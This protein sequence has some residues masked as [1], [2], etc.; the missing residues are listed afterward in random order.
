M[1]RLLKLDSIKNKVSKRT[2]A[3]KQPSR[4]A[5]SDYFSINSSNRELSINTTASSYLEKSLDGPRVPDFR[6]FISDEENVELF[7]DF[8]K[9]QYCQENIEFYVACEKFKNLDANA[10]L[11]SFMANQIYS[12]YLSETAK[13]PVN[14]N[15]D[16]LERIRSK[17]DQPEPGMFDDAQQEI[18]E[19][20][21]TDCYPRFCKTWRVDR[22]TA[23][24]ICQADQSSRRDSL[25]RTCVRNIVR[26][27]KS[28]RRRTPPPPPLP[29]KPGKASKKPHVEVDYH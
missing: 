3:K 14:L 24:K 2:P 29:P 5:L 19:L 4:A 9:S 27:T 15:H 1:N 12:A 25:R 8:L 7:R 16:C 6:T 22:E 21:R 11:M 23:N 10:E 17:L 28:C 26:R 13:Q 18:F 20:M